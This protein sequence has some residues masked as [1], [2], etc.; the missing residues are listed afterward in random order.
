M[1]YGARTMSYHISQP[2][3]W[4][5]RVT[6]IK[7]RDNAEQQGL[8]EIKKQV[9]GDMLRRVIKHRHDSKTQCTTKVHT[10]EYNWAVSKTNERKQDAQRNAVLL[11]AAKTEAPA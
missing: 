6:S 11:D 9:L 4:H 8:R 1:P 7:Q 2:D 5:K 3:S 10:L